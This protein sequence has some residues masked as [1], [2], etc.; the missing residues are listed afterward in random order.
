MSVK[1]SF[2]I[3]AAIRESS[4][5]QTNGTEKVRIGKH[6]AVLALFK[7]VDLRTDDSEMTEKPKNA[8]LN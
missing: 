3:K 4:D 7:D 2:Q 1:H 8:Q 6:D 5:S